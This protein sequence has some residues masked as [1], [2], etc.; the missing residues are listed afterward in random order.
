MCV[1]V[2]ELSNWKVEEIMFP[3]IKFHENRNFRNRKETLI[4]LDV[5]TGKEAFSA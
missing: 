3:N 2:K 4:F 5:D 1:V